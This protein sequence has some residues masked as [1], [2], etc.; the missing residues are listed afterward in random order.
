M[1]ITHYDD[2][3]GQRHSLNLIMRDID[4]V[5]ACNFDP[6]MEWAPRGGQGGI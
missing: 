4:C 5:S 3:V 2:A 1:S 6:L